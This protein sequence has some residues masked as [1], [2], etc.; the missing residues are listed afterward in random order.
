MSSEKKMLIDPSDKLPCME[1]GRWVT[2]EKHQIIRRYIDCSWAT[3]RKF[4]QRTYIDL[5][6][7]PGRVKIKHLEYY[8][9]GG[10]I[11]AWRIS[12][13]RKGAFTDF[14]IADSN[15][16]YLAGCKSR[17]A[18][19]SASVN[20]I[21]GS[22]HQTVDKILPRLSGSGL[23]L[24][25]LD[26]FNAGHL[27][28][29]IIEKLARKKHMDIVVHLSTGDIQRNIAASLKRERSPLDDFAPGWR[30][31]VKGTQSKKAMREAFLTHWSSLVAQTGLKICATKYPVMNGR[32]SIMYWLILLSRNDVANKLWTEACALRT[33]SL[34]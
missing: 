7:G 21:C 8:A 27:H 16:D 30:R 22:A 3:R 29:S 6:A 28:F 18:N 26:P 1:V 31:V 25:L 32:K 24:A 34:F 10:P 4:S 19:F 15:E 9:D 5:Y 2:E 33:K 17:L 23:H 14:F 13:L 12:N 20:A 11:A